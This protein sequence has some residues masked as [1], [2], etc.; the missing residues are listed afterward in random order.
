[1]LINYDALKALLRLIGLA[2][3]F[4]ASSALGGVI[5]QV[6]TTNYEQRPPV[7]EKNLAYVHGRRIKIGLSSSEG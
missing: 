1:M 4:S 3:A 6:E 7:V 5:M 2:I